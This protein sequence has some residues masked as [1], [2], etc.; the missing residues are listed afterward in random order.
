MEGE[1]VR[2]RSR[3][4]NNLLVTNQML[5][6]RG[7]AREKFC[8][9]CKLPPPPPPSENYDQ[10]LMTRAIYSLKHKKPNQI[11]KSETILKHV[12]MDLQQ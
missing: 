10:S 5:Y 1:G 3:G 8:L 11:F 6:S 12:T 9:L 4:K 2:G 7:S